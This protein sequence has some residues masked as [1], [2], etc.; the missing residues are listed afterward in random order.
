MPGGQLVGEGGA[1]GDLDALQGIHHQQPQGAI[2][3]VEVEDVVERR[4]RPELVV[5]PALLE[6]DGVG[7]E[8]VVPDVTEVSPSPISVGDV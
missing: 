2:E 3:D 5:G 8:A 6:G 4:P 7:R 1:N